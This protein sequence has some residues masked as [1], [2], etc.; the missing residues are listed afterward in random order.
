MKNGVL[1]DWRIR[2]LI[3]ERVILGIDEEYAD[4]AKVVSTSSLDLRVAAE[5]HKLIGSFIPLAGQRIQDAIASPRIADKPA[6]KKDFY[7]DCSQ[8]YLM[9]LVESLKLPT[10]IHAGIFNKSGRAR[11][12]IALHGLTDGNSCYDLVPAGYEGKLYAEVTSTAFPLTIDGGETAIPQIRFYE[13]KPT[14]LIGSELEIALDKFPILCD[15]KG[16]PS[17]DDKERR[18]MIETGELTLTTD[19]S[20]GTLAYIA[21][22]EKR[23]IELA[24]KGE[25][26]PEH[27]FSEVMCKNGERILTIHPGEFVL[28]KS[29][30]H[31]RLP[32]EFAAEIVPYSVKL[33]DMKTSYA[34]LINATHGWESD[35]PS[36]IIFEIKAIEKAITIQNGQP[37]VNFN[38]YRML[39][40]PEQK[41]TE[42]RSIVDFGNLRSLLPGQFKKD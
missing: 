9:R 24:K 7:L 3:R 32:P 4:K 28:I 6:N 14:P 19:L 29:R 1:P 37:L 36:Y 21:N 27:Y 34:N 39:G 18:R 8:P 15:D 20:Q 17:Y 35:K 26:Q 38:L 12:G 11:I 2:E 31:I 16:N 42:T 40:K 41:Y 30:E 10:T 25:Y 33:G 22:R 5:Q 23:V 13:G